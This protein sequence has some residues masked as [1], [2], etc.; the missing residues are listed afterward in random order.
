MYKRTDYRLKHKDIIAQKHTAH[1]QE[2]RKGLESQIQ[3]FTIHTTYQKF[4][5]AAISAI[6]HH[7][8]ETSST[9]EG[10]NVFL[11]RSVEHLALIDSH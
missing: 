10:T 7:L 5:S 4:Y 3:K 2:D 11:K 8:I 6:R 9:A 1:A